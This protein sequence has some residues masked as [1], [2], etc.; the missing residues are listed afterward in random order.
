MPIDYD[1]FRAALGKRVEL[2]EAE[3][4]ELGRRLAVAARRD[5]ENFDP[6][7]ILVLG[8][9]GVEEFV[10]TIRSVEPEDRNAPA[11]AEKQSTEQRSAPPQGWADRRVGEQ[12][13]DVVAIVAG[14][15]CAAVIL[16]AAVLSRPG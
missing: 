5:T 9:A 8:A 14:L 1:A 15:V 2:A 11:K 4:R 16:A 6:R 12:R 13:F 7:K 3:R 10:A